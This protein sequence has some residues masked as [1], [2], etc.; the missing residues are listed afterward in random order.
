[1]VHMDCLA[2]LSVCECWALAVFGVIPFVYSVFL[3]IFEVNRAPLSL[4]IKIVCITVS[5]NAEF[6]VLRIV[7]AVGVVSSVNVQMNLE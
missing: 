4:V 3:Y 1:M 5:P 7:S 6:F 2:R